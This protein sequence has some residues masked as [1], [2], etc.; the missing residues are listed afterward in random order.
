MVAAGLLV[1]RL[2][3]TLVL[4]AHAAHDLFGLFAGPGVG[5]GGVSNTATYLAGLGIGAPF[6]FAVV[7]QLILLAGAC[8]LAAGWY[9]RSAAVIVAA[10]LAV[11]IFQD[12]ARWGFFLNWTMD[13]TWG[14]GMEFALVQIG[15]AATIALAGPGD[16]SVDGWR[17]RAMAAAA[18]GRARIRWR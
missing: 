12:F 8:L 10:Y 16:L 18:A 2:T 5:P 14:H 15:I 1:L 17:A 3:L 9:A 7:G 11:M 13:P 4:V 6:V